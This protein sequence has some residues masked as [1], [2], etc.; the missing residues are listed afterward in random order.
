[1][2]PR[3][4]AAF[5]GAA[6]P[7]I[8]PAS[9]NDQALRRDMR[10]GVR[11][12]PYRPVWVKADGGQLLAVFGSHHIIEV[13]DERGRRALRYVRDRRSVQRDPVA[14]LHVAEQPQ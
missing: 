6:V 3:E 1:M 13:R 14:A 10:L 11:A 8:P 4:T 5:S 9:T 12:V 2:V 7:S